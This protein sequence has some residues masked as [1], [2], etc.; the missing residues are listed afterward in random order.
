[1]QVRSMAFLEY[2]LSLKFYRAENEGT[3]CFSRT[4]WPIL[5][6]RKAVYRKGFVRTSNGLAK[7]GRSLVLSAKAFPSGDI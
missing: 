3:R 2:H 4:V 7:C 6:E 1:M 5:R